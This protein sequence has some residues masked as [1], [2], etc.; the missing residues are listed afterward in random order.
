MTPFPQTV[1]QAIPP[2][3]ALALRELGLAGA[4]EV[5]RG[6]PLAGGVSSDIWRVDTVRGT[7]CAKR[8]LPQLRV[9][10]TWR[11]PIERNRYEAR[12]MEV[13]NAAVPGSAPQ[14]LGQHE[15]LGVLVMSYLPPGAHAL[16]KQQLR[17]GVAS[18]DTAR[19]VG[20][21]LGRIHAHSAA[22]PALATRF[23][24]DAIF[25][26]IRLE[27]YLLATAE[28]HPAHADALRALVAQTQSNARALVH[29]D[30]SPKNILVGQTCDGPDRVRPVLLDA[31]C[32]CWGD[33]A[34]DLAF[35][36]NHLLLKCL[37]TP[38]AR[39]GFLRCFAALTESY[40][41]QADWEPRHTLEG[42]AAALLPGLLLARVDGKSPVEYLTAATQRDAVRR[43]AC[44]LLHDRACERLQQVSDAWRVQWSQ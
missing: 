1:R 18:V 24:S 19:A 13:A 28:K 40:F 15:R 38:A 29:G 36:L 43:V 7:V 2:A 21:T 27:P 20:A 35:V 8:A 16:W 34:F 31:E 32:A 33:P 3:F 25:F 11:A 5:L 30:V 14:L 41:A 4:D 26:D 12:W 44:T 10:A 23:D 22:R 42:R 39:D 17:D 37:W 6:E 9:A